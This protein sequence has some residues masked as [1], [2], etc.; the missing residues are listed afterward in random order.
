MINIPHHLHGQ[1]P[2]N[3][4]GFKGPKWRIPV[5]QAENAAQTSGLGSETDK[6]KLAVKIKIAVGNVGLKRRN[7]NPSQRR[8]STL[9]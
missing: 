1:V 5:I 6:A 9:N 4:L 2:R 3:E 8:S 7:K